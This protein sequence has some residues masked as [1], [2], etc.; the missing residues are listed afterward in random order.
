MISIVIGIVWS[1]SWGWKLNIK[2]LIIDSYQSSYSSVRNSYASSSPLLP[3]AAPLAAYSAHL[4]ACTLHSC[5]SAHCSSALSGWQAA[6]L[7]TMISIGKFY[8]A[9]SATGLRS[10]WIARAESPSAL[11]YEA[12]LLAAMWSSLMSW[13]ACWSWA[14]ILWCAL[15]RECRKIHTI[16]QRWVCCLRKCL[17]RSVSW[18]ATACLFPLGCTS[19]IPHP[20]N[21]R[22]SSWACFQNVLF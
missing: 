2:I 3:T 18:L 15:T 8:S 17:Q 16:G 20:S 19:S 11:I 5:R 21:P 4:S 22:P 1:Q 7:M 6:Y 13:F 12:F 9:C 14:P 10:C